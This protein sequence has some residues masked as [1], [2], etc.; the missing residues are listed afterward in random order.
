MRTQVETVELAESTTTILR[1]QR[2]NAYFAQRFQSLQSE[3]SSVNTQINQSLERLNSSE[4]EEGISIDFLQNYNESES[5]E[6]LRLLNQE[7]VENV[8]NSEQQL[9]IHQEFRSATDNMVT[10]YNL[11]DYMVAYPFMSLGVGAV[12]FFSG[13]TLLRVF[14]N[15]VSST[16]GD[17]NP[18]MSFINN[19]RLSSRLSGAFWAW[20]RFKLGR[21]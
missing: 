20:L 18:S 17:Q 19:S 15:S 3:T 8:N 13:Y 1:V 6:D 5:V 2:N 16:I 10:I 12:V 11:F 9:T 14:R 4:T 7:V 21:N